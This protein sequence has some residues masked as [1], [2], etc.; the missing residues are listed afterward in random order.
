MKF[1]PTISLS[2]LYGASVS[3]SSFDH[4]AAA[5]WA[6]SCAYGCSEC[7][8]D[9]SCGCTYFTTHAL[10]HGGWSGGYEGTCATLWS[11]FKADKYA[12]WKYVSKNEADVQEG[13]AVIMNNGHDGDASHC[14]VGTGKGKVS[15]HNPGHK[16]VPPSTT[17]YSGGGI[18][19][20]YG[21]ADDINLEKESLHSQS[22]D[23]LTRDP[24]LISNDA[25]GT[26]H[27]TPL[28]DSI[29]SCSPYQSDACNCVYYARD[30]QPKLP[31]GCTTCD[32]KKHLSNSNQAK[33]GC[34][35]FR[36]GDPTYCHAAYV[37][38]VSGG[39]VYY[40]QAN[41]TPCECSSDSLSESS[42]KIIGY[43]CP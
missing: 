7:P 1:P 2:V 4:N 29:I 37:T 11:N 28:Q 31:G 16:D 12:N 25:A 42:D 22:E 38:K 19:A 26:N 3:G 13:F 36:T 6:E 10:V 41:W 20:I 23:K 30:R 8:D 35:L 33:P 40:D 5:E 15:C 18:N 21:W 27:T 43:Y 14:C 32:D 39:K 17:W 9:N 34:V 24:L